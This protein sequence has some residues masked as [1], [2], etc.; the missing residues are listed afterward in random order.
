MA[1]NVKINLTRNKPE[2]NFNLGENSSRIYTP[3]EKITDIS[4]FMRFDP[5]LLFSS[6]SFL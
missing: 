1:T 2:Y 5:V 3:G 4:N 6:L